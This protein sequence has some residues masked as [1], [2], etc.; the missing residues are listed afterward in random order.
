MKKKFLLKGLDCASCAAKIEKKIGELDF[1]ED[2]SYSFANGVLT[3]DIAE[4]SLS[5]DEDMVKTISKIVDSIEHGVVVSELRQKNLSRSEENR[6]TEDNSE[7]DYDGDSQEARKRHYKIAAGALLLVLL[8]TARISWPYDIL[9]YV[10]A[11]LLAGSGVLLRAAKDI[12]RGKLFD[13]N[14]LMSIATI[15]AFMLGEYSEAVGVMLFYQ[16]GEAFQSHA[17]NNSRRSIKEILNIRPKYANIK[18]HDKVESVSPESVNPGDIIVVRPG[19]RV[20]LDGEVLSGSSMADTSALTGEPVPRRVSKGDSILSGF[21]NKDSLIEVRVTK[22]FEDSAV[23]R[24]LEMVESAGARKAPTEQFITRFSRYY[25]PFVVAAAVIIALIPPLA[26]FG[27]FPEWIRRSLIFLVISCPCALVVSIPL[28]FF[29]GIGT[30]SRNG[31]LVK[32][33]NYLEALNYVGTVVFDKTGT[34][35]KGNFEVAKIVPFSGFSMDELLKT[36]AR[37]ESHS[38]HPIA[39]SIKRAY[40]RDLDMGDITVYSEHA[41]QGVSATIDGK[42]VLAGNNKL[43]AQ[44]G[45]LLPMYSENG[46]IVHVSSDGRYIGYIVIEDELKEGVSDSVA[47]LKGMGVE[48]VM[49]FT[50]DRMI[51]AEAVAKEIGLDGFRAE[52]LPNG[53]VEAFE[54]LSDDIEAASGKRGRVAF[55][56]DG[57]NDAPVLARADVGISMGALGSDAAIE[58]A[59]IVIMDDKISKIATAISIAKYTK[60]IVLQ[61]IVLA[62]GV[63][64]AVMLLGV[65]GLATMWMAVFADVGVAL[66]AIFNSARI[67]GRKFA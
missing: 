61:N 50:G 23:S 56:G 5:E 21:I 3:L 42:V 1:V 9:I 12:A 16:I 15:G 13:E 44:N 37:A 10:F 58:A 62:L 45:I 53:K 65:F 39:E 31:I 38:N 51:A 49:M 57:I 25:T 59:D 33:G 63:K 41:G 30:A 11:Y 8:N 26:G 22:E 55:V 64:G 47:K 36:A 35:T 52:L 19:E 40:D 32:G 66:L 67:L 6:E 54:K 17:V 34:L 46:T 24:I 27:G 60:K 28:G 14:F 2:A 48:N 43:M 4:G 29:G 20:P 7:E 18:R